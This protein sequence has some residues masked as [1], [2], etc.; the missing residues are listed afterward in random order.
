MSG[1]KMSKEQKKAFK[2]VATHMAIA[3]GA[4]A[5]AAS[6]PLMG[7]GLFGKGLATHVAAKAVTRSLASLHLFAEMGHIGHGVFELMSHI[8]SEDEGKITPEQAMAHLVMASVAKELDKLTDKDYTEV[9]EKIGPEEK[10][11]AV[12]QRYLAS[13]V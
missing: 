3:A 12:V 4:A 1:K 11:A 2:E 10:T 7:A 13:N 8:A 6:G 9:L 5:F